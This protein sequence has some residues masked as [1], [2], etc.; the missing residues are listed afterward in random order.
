MRCNQSLPSHLT[1][2]TTCARRW[3]NCLQMRFTSFKRIWRLLAKH[4]ASDLSTV[5][6]N[7]TVSLERC[8]RLSPFD[9]QRTGQQYTVTDFAN[10]NTCNVQLHGP[11]TCHFHVGQDAI[12][13]EIALSSLPIPSEGGCGACLESFEKL[14]GKALYPHQETPEHDGEHMYRLAARMQCRLFATADFC[15]RSAACHCND[16][17]RSSLN[18]LSP[19]RPHLM[20]FAHLAV[21][22]VFANPTASGRRSE[23]TSPTLTASSGA[24]TLTMA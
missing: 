22:L 1:Q 17:V 13:P 9:P 6:L 11:E 2:D 8:M 15:A 7:S 16:S 21:H 24:R 19:I 5:L 20:E 23:G 3:P 10:D 14:P 12:M 4:E 18:G